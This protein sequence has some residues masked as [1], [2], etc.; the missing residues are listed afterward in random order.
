MV[1]VIVPSISKLIGL[2]RN[3]LSMM[4]DCMW[5]VGSGVSSLVFFSSF[6][7]EGKR[8][9][10]VKYWGY[11]RHRCIP[12]VKFNLKHREPFAC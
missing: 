3:F 11:G 9:K 4:G 6:T 8:E 5:T 10:G 7:Y 12:S 1:I 2:T